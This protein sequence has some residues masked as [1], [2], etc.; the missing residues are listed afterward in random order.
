[1]TDLVVEVPLDWWHV[2]CPLLQS[3]YQRENGARSGM[4]QW[5]APAKCR[6]AGPH[7]PL[8]HGGETGGRGVL[9]GT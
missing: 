6:E 3:S 2:A 9:K 4:T 1:M 5:V 8:V 7:W